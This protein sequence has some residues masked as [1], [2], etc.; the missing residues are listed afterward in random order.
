MREQNLN[1]D[2]FLPSC[3]CAKEVALGFDFV[4]LGK[5]GMPRFRKVPWMR[6]SGKRSDGEASLEEGRLYEEAAADG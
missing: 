5:S 1:P 2:L 3:F 4:L 6:G